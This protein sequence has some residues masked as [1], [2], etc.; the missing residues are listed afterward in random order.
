MF[1]EKWQILD[2]KVQYQTDCDF[3]TNIK[4]PMTLESISPTGTIDGFTKIMDD[5]DLLHEFVAWFET[6]YTGEERGKGVRRRRIPSTFLVGLSNTHERTLNR[7]ANANDGVKG[8]HNRGICYKYK[9][10]FLGTYE[11]LENWRVSF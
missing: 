9:S 2:L 3:N 1:T 4:S 10:K 7:L 5:E 8:L 6:Y 11:C